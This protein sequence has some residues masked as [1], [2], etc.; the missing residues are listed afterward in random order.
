MDYFLDIVGYPN[1]E[2]VVYTSEHNMVF[3]PVV[4]NMDKKQRIMY[5]LYRDCTK[6][7][8]GHHVKVG[9][10]FILA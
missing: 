6:Y 3:A 7:M 5:K 10:S 8:D 4:E 2:V 9:I 1:F